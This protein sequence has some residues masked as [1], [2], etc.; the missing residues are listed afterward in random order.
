MTRIN[1]HRDPA[2]K[3]IVEFVRDERELDREI[4]D[5]LAYASHALRVLGM[6]RLTVALCPGATAVRVEEGRQ[7]GKG[8]G[9]RWAI[10]SI[11]ADAS[12]VSIALAVLRLARREND[13]YALDLVMRAHV[14]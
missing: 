8:P 7:L 11:P 12:R 13:A 5:R 10:L 14:P 9:A 1:P 6:R 2:G 4:F 3:R